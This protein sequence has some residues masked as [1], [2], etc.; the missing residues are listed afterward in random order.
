MAEAIRCQVA[1]VGSGPAGSVT[2]MTL[3][4]KGFDVVMLEE[5]PYL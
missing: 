4:S 5:G 2:A 3:A 1:V